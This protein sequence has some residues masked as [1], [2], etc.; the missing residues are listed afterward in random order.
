MR[1]YLRGARGRVRGEGC[2]AVFEGREG[3]NVARRNS[4][5]SSGDGKGGCKVGRVLK[6][7]AFARK[8]DLRSRYVPSS[9]FIFFFPC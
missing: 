1:W 4:G 2:F 9:L 6:S 3:K 8:V 7:H 5:S